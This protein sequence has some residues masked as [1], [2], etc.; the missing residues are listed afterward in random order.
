VTDS[1]LQAD[2][3]RRAIIVGAGIGGLTASTALE[4]AGI[5]TILL[6]QMDRLEEVGAGLTLAP[7]AMSVMRR[8]G[9]AE[10]IEAAGTRLEHIEHRTWRGKL[11]AD[12]PEGE[13]AEKLGEPIVGLTRPALLRL[14]AERV[15]DSQLHLRS[16][17]RGVTQDGG[18][19]AAV[20]ED[21]TEIAGAVV[22]GADG[23]NSAVRAQLDRTPLNYA[24]Y[25]TWRGLSRFGDVAPGV[26]VQSYGR[27]S[28]F[29]IIPVGDGIT[30]WYG[31]QNA[32]AGG[33]DEPG[34]RKEALVS[35]FRGW[36]DPIEPLIEA[37][38]EDTIA[39]AD[40]FDLPKRTTWGSGRVTLLGDAAHPTAPTLGQGACMAIEDG[41]VLAKALV[42]REDPAEALRD[43]ERRRIERTASIVK[44]SRQQGVFTQWERPWACALRDA[45]L[46]A[47]PKRMALRELEKVARFDG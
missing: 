41:E 46:R 47:M 42:A 17:C 10:A 19:A 26:H 16:R 40:I 24:G 11:L 31:S 18:S 32:P 20:L 3:D 30:Y 22:V 36:H 8:L 12:W 9:F 7:N 45:I 34:R 21:G 35:L 6:E 28:I 1:E 25:T 23:I 33:K 14:L 2:D 15:Q 44:Q 39:R 13:V 43:Y 38:E 4:R 27:G 29:G 5:R 37:A